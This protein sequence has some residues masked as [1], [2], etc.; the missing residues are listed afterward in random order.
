MWLIIF[1]V[2]ILAGVAGAFYLA[3][4]I[5]KTGIFTELIHINSRVL[6]RVMSLIGVAFLGVVLCCLF[7]VTN[8]IIIFIHIAVFMLVGDLV[9]LI[10][11]RSGNVTISPRLIDLIA[12][13]CCFA[14][15]CVGW[16]LM[17]GLWETDYS[18]TTDK[19]VTAI[20]VAHIA[21]SHIGTGFSGKGFGE[22]LRR[23][24]EAQP[25]MLVITGDFVDDSTTKQ[26]MI[27]A[28][29]QLGKIDMK[30]GKFFC[31][32]NHDMGYYSNERRGYSG[33]DLIAELE[34]NGV[35]VLQD[36]YEVVADNYYVIGRKDAGY[37]QGDRTAIGEL[38]SGLDA[39]KYMIVLDHQPVDYEAEEASGVDLVLSGHTHGGQLWP[40]EYIQ[41]LV[42][43][44]DNV[45]GHERRTN[46][47]FI[48]TDGISDWAIK[49]RTGCKSE[50]NII[51]IKNSVDR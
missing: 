18:L 48:V 19:N 28:C 30:Y 43:Q 7:D 10:I 41:P 14:Y 12:L 34:K 20:R 29:E 8:T 23:I 22:K 40:L 42:S 26:D 5:E 3:G 38:V 6:I 11:Q 13:L 32:G 50:F 37:G 46:T 15:F 9:C 31:F 51:D 4:K 39:D 25:D 16:Y 47:D 27:D 44:N 17:H 49:F 35:R 21:D 24:N 45:R 1:A 33:E 36:E 2:S